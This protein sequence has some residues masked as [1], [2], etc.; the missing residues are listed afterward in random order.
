MAIEKNSFVIRLVLTLILLPALIFL[1]KVGVAD[2]LRLEPCA[3]VEAL[4]KGN[5]TYDPDKLAG[6]RERLL[7]AR[8]WDAGN[9]VIPEFLGHADY[10][11]AQVS[12]FDLTLQAGYLRKAADDFDAAIALRPNSSYLWASR[13]TTGSWL[14]GL[15]AS[16]GRDK[17]LA[18]A[19]F[20]RIELSL[21]R[22]AALGPWEPAVLK[23][24]VRV[25]S[26][27]YKEFSPEDRQIV[28]GAIA[29]AKQLGI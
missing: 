4:M 10:I 14:L 13:L 25:G 9:P 5:E 11:L 19:E 22:A 17:E 23:Q 1:L 27:R 15:N 18:Q 12:G 20:A 2:F 8:S 21:R 7:L 24:I 26:F 3:Y 16:L 6:S 29:R 28:D